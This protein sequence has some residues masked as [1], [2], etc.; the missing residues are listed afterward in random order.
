MSTISSICKRL[1]AT[2]AYTIISCEWYVY[3]P[4]LP[5]IG[6]EWSEKA[7]SEASRKQ[8]FVYIS[9]SAFIPAAK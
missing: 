8:G 2:C 5:E 4:D 7:V 1:S 3:R 9:S 6:N